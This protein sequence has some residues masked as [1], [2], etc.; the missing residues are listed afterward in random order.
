[1]GANQAQTCLDEVLVIE[2][3]VT[4]RSDAID[5]GLVH[6]VLAWSTT[7]HGV[8][9]VKRSTRGLVNRCTSR[10][11]RIQEKCALKRLDDKEACHA[12]EKETYALG[13]R[14]L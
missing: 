9:T 6:L 13:R 12:E 4:L 1:M 2:G 7:R 5:H 8:G 11:Y 10:H 3:L 14:D